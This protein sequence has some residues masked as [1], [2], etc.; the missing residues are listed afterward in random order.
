[1]NH[2][3][4]SMERGAYRLFLRSFESGKDAAAILWAAIDPPRPEVAEGVAGLRRGIA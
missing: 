2:V 4:H 3:L 1:M